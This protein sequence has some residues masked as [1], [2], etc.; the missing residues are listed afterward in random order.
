M[1]QPGQPSEVPALSTS[2]T[3]HAGGFRAPGNTP[4]SLNTGG[5]SQAG[6]HEV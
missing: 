4:G 2:L 3:I 6:N 1:V 5:Y